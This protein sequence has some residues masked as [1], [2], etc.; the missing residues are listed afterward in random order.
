MILLEY[1]RFI[2]FLV[3]AIM[4]GYIL[5]KNPKSLLNITCALLLSS[6]AIWTIADPDS[7]SKDVTKETVI[8]FRNISS[9]GWIS[10]ASFF[11]CFALVFSKR[12]KLLKKKWVLIFIFIFPIILLY[13]QW[14]TGLM[15]TPTMEDFGWYLSWKETFWAYLFYVYYSSFMLAGIYIIYRHGT[16][17]KQI[18]EKKQSQII[19]ATAFISLIGATITDIIMPLLD[20]HVIPQIGKI[21]LFVF[22][23]GIVYAIVKYEFLTISFAIAAENIISNMEELLILTDD[24]GKILN[25]NNAVIDS[26]K[27]EH[28]ELTGQSVAILFNENSL[29]KSILGKISAGEIV[30]SHESNL[31]A[32]DA[33]EIP[34]LFSASSLKDKRGDV[35]GIVFI[36]TDISERKRVEETLLE[37]EEKYHFLVQNSQDI[38]YTINLDGIFTFVSPAWTTLL[39]QPVC[40]VLGKSFQQF[41][42]PDDLLAYMLLMQELLETGQTQKDVVYRMQHID[43]SW[44]WHSSNGARIMNEKGEIVGFHGVGRDITERKQAEEALA[45][46]QSLMNALMGNLPDYIYFKDKE[47]RF[48]KINE[49][50]AKLFKLSSAEDAIGKTDFDFFSEE[51]ARRAY[52]D[53]QEIVLSGKIVTSEEKETWN[54]QPDTWVSTTKLPLRNQ[55]G[56]II[57]TFG[58]SMDITKRKRMEEDLRD[59]E[60]RY[61]L[62]IETVNEG[63]LVAQNGFLKFVNPMMQVITGYTQEEL[64]TLPFIEYVYPDDW[65][66]VINNHMERLKGEQFVPRY[67]FRIVKKN[68]STRSI[69]MNGIAIEW[70]GSP[71]TLNMLTDITERKQ[72][73]TEIKLKNEQ[74]LEL[75]AT[76]DKF[77]S[78]IA[79]DLRGPFNVFLGLTELMAEDL[80]RY[81]LDQIQEFSLSL[82]N[83]ATNL[84]NLLENLLQW[85]RMQQGSISFNPELLQLHPVIDE[86]VVV[87][88]DTAKNKGIEIRIT[89]PEGLEVFADRNML[90]TVVRNLVSNALKFTP[91]GGTI[92]VSAKSS[93][94][95][96]VELSIKDTGIGMTCEMMNKLFRIDVQTNRIGTDGEPSSGLGLLLCK[97]FVEKHGGEIWAESEVEKGTIFYFTIPLKQ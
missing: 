40:D 69:E 93:D 25:V 18:T 51:H 24:E 56:A 28:K 80:Q 61:R 2:G 68:G 22:A 44:R 7:L 49:A 34:V 43:G 42:H 32:K 12:E 45:Q 57:G 17:T 85:S 19:V 97:E 14:T 81:T 10:F 88:L 55:N 41:V 15:N 54:D 5:C 16:Q 78:I 3:Y 83:S 86:C 76:K 29:I 48:I 6:F 11:V 82:R 64:L 26:L 67:Q 21:V 31:L 87:A 62:L 79:H 95:K 59:S 74:L 37:S 58:R 13:Q 47:S 90:Q 75:N 72:A 70:E 91:R 96:G 35:R 36:A 94:N 60:R 71:A 23:G 50:H 65:E 66:I 52:N 77:F 73:E 33:S 39:G 53:E 1:F 92:R 20:I 89:I 46:E 27:Y 9:I 30:I 8:L 4:A 84:F 63:I 38:I